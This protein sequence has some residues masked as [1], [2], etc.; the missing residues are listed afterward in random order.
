[1]FACKTLIDKNY[2][3]LKHPVFIDTEIADFLETEHICT[4]EAYSHFH[5]M[6]ATGF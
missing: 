1:M 5:S 4:Y 2:K 6:F 3:K